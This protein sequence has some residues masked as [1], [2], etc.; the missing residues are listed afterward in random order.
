MLLLH[1][2][3]I[4]TPMFTRMAT[5][6]IVFASI[7]MTWSQAV[8]ATGQDMTFDLASEVLV[9]SCGDCHSGGADEGGFAI[10]DLASEAS[11][12]TQFHRWRK[13]RERLDER[14]MPPSDAEPLEDDVNASFVTWIETSTTNA[15]IERGPIAGPPQFRRL[16]KYE[17]SNTIR[18]LL[19]IHFNA[20][21]G[22]PEDI[23]G[24][25]G[26]A[27]AAE[28]LLI[29]PAIAD[30]YLQAAI[31][32]LDYASKDANAREQLISTVPNESTTEEGAARANLRRLAE[33]AFRRPVSQQELDGFVKLFVEARDDD[34]PFEQALLF[35]M[36]GILIS[37]RFLFIAEQ[38]P[39]EPDAT[40]PVS[41][42]ELAVRLSYFL[43]ASMPD[44]KLRQL[45]DEGRLNNEA[46]LEKQ[47]SRL[48]RARGTHLQDSMEQ[49][50][51]SW[52]GTADLGSAKQ[53]DRVRFPRMTD[54]H[55]AA[56]RKQPVVVM[57]S[58]LRNNDSLLELID[59][60]WTFLNNELVTVYQL[61]R[62]K[63]EGNFVQRLVRVELPDEYRYRSGL[64]GM[65]GVMAVNSYARRGSPILRGAFILEKMLGVELPPPPPEVPALDESKQAAE[66]ATLRDRLEQHRANPACATC[67]DRIDPI[68]FALENFDELGR[69]RDR[70]Q[71]GEIDATTLMADGRQVD[72]VQGLKD[73]LM[74]RKET[75][76]RVLARKMLG[77]AL[78]RSLRESDQYAIEKIVQ[79]VKDNEYRSQALV[80]GIV[81]S[82]PFR[83]KRTVGETTP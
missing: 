79:R 54:P 78:G 51:G 41:D 49:F 67:H 4:E 55:V 9:E 47:V 3:H 31:A 38:P 59:A 19:G 35:A 27:N 29:S 70:D 83:N 28:T 34:T 76:V 60:D 68:G 6:M 36:R 40:E 39:V 5:L 63:I 72:G 26:F 7:A 23:A 48:I 57:E 37:P 1:P 46:E 8:R 64:L 53:I 69:W 50:V 24:G 65:G 62:N 71:G 11:L 74:S 2:R 13:V 75:F 22:L 58:I 77:Y 66:A 21:Q 52:L 10:E 81:M 73:Y 17:Y 25:E 32:A 45:A 15:I 44:E 30:Q 56:L 14:T 43:W 42:H 33:R 12:V 16:A 18:D 20:G 80:L 82:E 61:R